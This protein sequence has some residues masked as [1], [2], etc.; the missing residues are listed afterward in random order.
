[1]SIGKNI[2]RFR[3]KKGFTQSEL[4]EMLGV[5]NQAV[6]K[7]ES[8]MT[9]PDIML[10][11]EIAKA[12]GVTLTDLYDIPDEK[13]EELPPQAGGDHGEDRRILV[14]HVI[15]DGA[16]VTTRMP[17]SAI[18]SVFGNQLLKQYLG[19]GEDKQ[20]EALLEMLDQ[21][22]TGTLV[23]VDTEEGRVTISMEEY[24]N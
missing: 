9:M 6:S 18:K 12:L 16:D 20:L 24:Q 5:S 21:N 19:E 7:W 10:L 1:M 11:P 23:N 14:I 4:G 22:T 13:R 8:D 17:V 2:A 3:R 15:A